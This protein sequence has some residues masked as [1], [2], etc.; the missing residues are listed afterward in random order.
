M[1]LTGHAPLALRA[2]SVSLDQNR[3]E[4]AAARPVAIW[5][6]TLVAKI[7]GRWT[8][9]PPKRGSAPRSRPGRITP[10]CLPP[11]PTGCWT[12]SARGLGPPRLC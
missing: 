10:V 5:S 11:G 6:L 9:L 2:M 1:A 3:A 7:T 4:L 8:I 12:T